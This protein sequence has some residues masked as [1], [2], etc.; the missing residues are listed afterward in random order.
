MQLTNSPRTSASNWMS[1][2]GGVLIGTVLLITAGAASGG[3]SEIKQFR[4]VNS[5]H[6]R[7]QDGEATLSKAQMLVTLRNQA[8]T[9]LPKDDEPFRFSNV[10]LLPDEMIA[11]LRLPDVQMENFGA[12]ELDGVDGVIWQSIDGLL[13]KPE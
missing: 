13:P 10:H 6:V 4:H 11:P 7:S 8:F 1:R 12:F 5:E 9:A 3:A 2:M